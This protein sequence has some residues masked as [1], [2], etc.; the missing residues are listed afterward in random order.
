MPTYAKVEAC[1]T[2][3]GASKFIDFKDDTWIRLNGQIVFLVKNYQRASDNCP[4]EH[5]LLEIFKC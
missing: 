5:N 3:I 2:V 4:I 1:E